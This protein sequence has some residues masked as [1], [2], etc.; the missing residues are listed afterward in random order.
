MFT[1]AHPLCC[2]MICVLTL[3]VFLPEAFAHD[4]PSVW[5]MPSPPPP[6]SPDSFLALRSQARHQQLWDPFPDPQFWLGSPPLGS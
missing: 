1:Q 2:Q 5:N 3:H 6:L 4:G